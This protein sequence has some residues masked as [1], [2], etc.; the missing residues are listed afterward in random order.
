MYSLFY[1]GSTVPTNKQTIF[2]DKSPVFYTLH[3]SFSM[4]KDVNRSMDKAVNRS[5]HG[6][7]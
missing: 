4:D 2:K 6:W 5:M 7:M 1:S 3:K